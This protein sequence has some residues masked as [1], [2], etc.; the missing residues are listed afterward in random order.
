MRRMHFPG[1]LH[2][3]SHSLI[4]VPDDSKLPIFYFAFDKFAEG[5]IKTVQ[6]PYL[7]FKPDNLVSFV[8]TQ[9][10]EMKKGNKPHAYLFR[11]VRCKNINK[12]TSYT[13]IFEHLFLTHTHTILIIIR[14]VKKLYLVPNLL[15]LVN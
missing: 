6:Q 10:I 8:C 5:G 11:K 15:Q 12:T 4:Y 13:Y 3:C 7:Q 2:F 1:R 14:R 9:V